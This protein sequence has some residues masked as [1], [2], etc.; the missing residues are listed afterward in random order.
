M[1]ISEQ[2][3][4]NFRQLYFGGNWT[5]VN[6]QESL[7]GVTWQQA[8]TRVATLNTIAALVYHVNYYVEAAIEVLEGR[9]LTAK[10]VYSFDHP[11][12]ES[13]EDWE[14]LLQRTWKAADR[15]SQLVGR[16]PDN[17]LWEPFAEEKY[18]NYYRNIH[19]IIEHSHYHLGQVVLIKKLLAKGQSA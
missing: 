6:L 8:M 19:G 16:L 9:L 1:N 11:T 10:D 14:Q 2:I 4:G 12:I 13:Q 5:A 18:G 15:F 17:L 7:A 3:A